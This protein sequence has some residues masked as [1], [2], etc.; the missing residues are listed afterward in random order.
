MNR[1]A[2]VGAG[3]LG[4][5]VAGLIQSLPNYHLVGFID[6]KEGPVGGVDVVGND[7]V[8]DDLLRTGIRELVVC[9][10]DSQRRVAIGLELRN[11][12]FLLPTV[13]HP[14]AQL[15][16]GSRV[17]GG[18][19]ILPGAVILPEAEIGEFCVIEAGSFVGHHARVGDGTLVGARAVVG[20]RTTLGDSVIIGMGANVRSGSL[21]AAGTRVAD[22]NL[23]E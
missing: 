18:S 16:V 12:G 20:N 9:I 21:V 19:I 23:W 8:L 13:M 14:A 11:R 5:N 22:F 15:G 1:I 17:G 2:L 6:D 10:G 7:S 4:L 3:P